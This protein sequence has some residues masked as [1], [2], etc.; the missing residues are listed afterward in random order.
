M[1]LTGL[2]HVSAVTATA[3]NNISFY[4]QTMGLRLV[5]KTVNQDD[6]S[7][8]HL[9]YGNEAGCPG[10]EVTFF[11][12]PHGGRNIPGHGMIS[13]IG[14]RVPGAG[15]LEWWQRRLSDNGVEHT[16]IVEK[17]GRTYLQF[18]DAE[19]QRLSL[20]DDGGAALSTAWKKSDVP[21][22]HFVKGLHSVTLEVRRP[23]LTAD[24]LTDVM[25]MRL[26][27]E[28]EDDGR[29]VAVYAM[30]PG[31]PGA[32]V[33]LL[34]RK[35]LSRTAVGAGGVH[36][37]AFRT[38]NQ[39]EQSQWLARLTDAGIS[40]S[41]LVDRYYFRSL[42]FREPGGILFEIATDGPGFATDKSQDHLGERLALPPFLE[43]RR[44]KIEAGL[45]PL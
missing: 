32:E 16:D 36:H 31:G 25:G 1:E 30:G 38:P 23:D 22:E 24:V 40:T 3:P 15:S 11:D 13:S 44:S 34:E 29:L 41:G 12:W 35:Q 27:R 26:D 17:G 2:H 6:V 14:L 4:T 8:Y 21:Q 19:G 39:A 28:Y 43:P 37:V 42:Y 10:T 33:A 45:I 20:F 18:T 5:K 7:S 9:F